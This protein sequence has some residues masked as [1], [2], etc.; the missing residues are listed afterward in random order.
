MSK[1]LLM[2]V[3]LA[4]VVIPAV[5]AR[6]TLPRR[7]LRRTV[8]AMLAFNIIYAFLVIVVYPKICWN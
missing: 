5:A 1:L 2:S 3:V 7:G 6:D 4:T 8:L